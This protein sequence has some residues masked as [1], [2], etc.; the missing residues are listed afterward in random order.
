MTPIEIKKALLE[1]GVSMRSIALGMKPPV[2]TNA[3]S[4]VVHRKTRSKRI[5]EAVA[6]AIGKE[7]YAVFPEDLTSHRKAVNS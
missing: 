7:L 2:S 4:L 3:V 5:M 6:K 1:K